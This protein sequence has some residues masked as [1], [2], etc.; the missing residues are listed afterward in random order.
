MTLVEFKDFNVLIGN[1]PFPDQLVKNKQEA[2]EKLVEIS[3]NDDYAT[4]NL[5]YFLY[6]HK[7]YRLIGIDLSSKTHTYIPQQISF[8]QKFATMFFIVEKQQKTTLT[9]L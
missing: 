3:R 5:L 8:I 4:G 1:K 7:Y 2:I 6:H 9:F